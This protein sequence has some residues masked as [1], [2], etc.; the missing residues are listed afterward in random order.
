MIVV[1]AI[2]ITN[3]YSIESL[4]L[5]EGRGKRGFLKQ[6]RRRSVGGATLI[7]EQNQVGAAADAEFCE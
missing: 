1:T 2:A 7:A 6:R 4:F 3:S 5:R